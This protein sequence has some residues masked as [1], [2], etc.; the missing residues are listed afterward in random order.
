MHP[1]AAKKIRPFFSSVLPPERAVFF[2]GGPW[3]PRFPELG[4]CQ[5]SNPISGNYKLQMICNR[6]VG[7]WTKF[8][9]LVQ[10]IP[11]SPPPPP[12]TA[13]GSPANK[14]KYKK[15][16]KDKH[17]DKCT[18]TQ[19]QKYQIHNHEKIRMQKVKCSSSAYQLLGDKVAFVI[20]WYLGFRRSVL[21]FK[22][23]ENHQNLILEMMEQ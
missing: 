3:L 7:R 18:H 16:Q 10:K 23:K 6:A 20:R 4:L 22:K 1:G 17:K 8:S 12:L 19:I 21:R 5:Q 11:L 2:V 15:R 9:N 14:D 13:G